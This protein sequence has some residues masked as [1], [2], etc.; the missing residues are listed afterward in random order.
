MTTDKKT[1]EEKKDLVLTKTNGSVS[2]IKYTNTDLNIIQNIY[3]P[4]ATKAEF[5][6]M[7][8]LSKEYE[9]DIM[10]REIW[11]VKYGTYP[12]Q[13][14][15]GR[16]GFRTIAHRSGKFKGWIN[17]VEKIDEPL[18]ALNRKGEVTLTREFSYKATCQI[19]RTDMEMPFEKTVYE[20]EY[21]SGVELWLTKP[22][23]MI[24]KVAQ[25]QCLREA[26]SISGVY[27]PVEL[28]REP[29]TP[30]YTVENG[31]KRSTINKELLQIKTVEQMDLYVMEFETQY[32]C[33]IMSQR[34]GKRG[35]EFERWEKCFRPHVMR[36]NQMSPIEQVEQ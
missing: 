36:V 26:F 2:A 20:N 25:C 24:E 7:I 11:L 22:R 8:H 4:K 13:I 32:G 5:N 19:F 29:I 35:D 28:E 1:T 21:S 15:V 31:P 14:F 30:E 27:D 34:S 17:K 16:D 12:A 33:N 6:L 18:K 10:K 3:A 23:T 9:L